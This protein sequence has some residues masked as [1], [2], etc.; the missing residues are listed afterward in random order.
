MDANYPSEMRIFES[1]RMHPWI[2][3]HKIFIDSELARLCAVPDTKNDGERLKALYAEKMVKYLL[4]NP[5]EQKKLKEVEAEEVVV[6]VVEKK[7]KTKKKSTT[8]PK[9]S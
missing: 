3:E 4:E 9:K 1:L 2:P 8:S 5:L 7:E 6:K